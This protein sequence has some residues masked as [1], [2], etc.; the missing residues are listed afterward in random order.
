MLR[1]PLLYAYKRFNII[2]KKTR[3]NVEVFDSKTVE[4]PRNGAECKKQ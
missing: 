3:C 1:C 2:R 4:E